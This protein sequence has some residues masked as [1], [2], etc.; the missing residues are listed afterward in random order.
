MEFLDVEGKKESERLAAERGPFPEWAQSIWGPDETCARDEN[1]KRI[2][3]MQLLRNCN[4]TTVAPTGTISHHRRLLLG[5]RAAVRRRV[6][7]QP[8]RRDDARRER[9]L[10]RDREGARAGT[11]TR[12]WSASRR[13]G[14][15]TSPRCRRSGSACSSRRTRSR[16]SGTCKMQAAFQEH[17]D[18][19]ISKTTNF[20]HTATVDDVRKIYELAYEL[21]CK[22]VTVYR[23]GSRDNQVLSHRRHGEGEGGARGRRGQQARS[24]ASWR[25]ELA[26]KDAEIERLKKALYDVEAENLQRRAK[27]SRPDK[28][29]A[30]SIRKE[31]PL[32]VMFVNITEDEKGQPFEVFVTLGKAGG[33]AMADA[34]AMGRLI[35]LALRSGIPLMEIHRQLRG[36]SLGSRGGSRTE[37]GAVGAGR[38]R[39]RDRRVVARQAGGAAGTARRPPPRSPAARRRASR[40]PRHRP[41][42]ARRCR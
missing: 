30:T 22:G 29:R 42:A 36:I 19:A 32:G 16:P 33:S 21:N 7:A 41:P 34:E 1:G 8:G 11:P 14:T 3:P 27:R 35:S 12:S 31:T 5:P 23:D 2:R 38:D 26:E 37:Q 20:A 9:G 4:V 17:C 40:S 13:K 6:H 25:G 24:S 10:R 39:Y 18:S 28:L 15:S